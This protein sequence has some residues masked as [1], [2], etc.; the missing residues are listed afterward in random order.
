M[1]DVGEPMPVDTRCDSDEKSACCYLYAPGVGAV[2]CDVDE[3]SDTRSCAKSEECC[4]VVE[5]EA[6]FVGSS[7]LAFCVSFLST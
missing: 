3:A 6:V 5:V 1:V 4:D 7:D 2:V